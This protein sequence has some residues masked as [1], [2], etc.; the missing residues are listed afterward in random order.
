MCITQSCSA[1]LGHTT[2]IDA[3]NPNKAEH[4]NRIPTSF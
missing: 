4:G 2:A 1:N 3:S